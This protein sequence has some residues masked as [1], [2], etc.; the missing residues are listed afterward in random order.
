MKSPVRMRSK[1][2]PSRATWLKFR[3][4]DLPMSRWQNSR[5]WIPALSPTPNVAR[6]WRQCPVNQFPTTPNF[7]SFDSRP[8]WGDLSLD[9]PW[10]RRALATWPWPLNGRIPITCPNLIAVARERAN[11]FPLLTSSDVVPQASLK[12][13]HFS[14]V[15]KIRTVNRKGKPSF[16]PFKYFRRS[17]KISSGSKLSRVWRKEEWIFLFVHNYNWFDWLLAAISLRLISD[18]FQMILWLS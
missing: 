9:G 14:I 11:V 13:R 12:I 6:N 3:F 2:G 16:P 5:K 4:P 17:S 18:I 1:S 8:V 15:E 10:S 7:P